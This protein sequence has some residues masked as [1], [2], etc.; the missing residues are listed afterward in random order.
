MS[1]SFPRRK[2]LADLREKPKEMR[3]TYLPLRWALDAAYVTEQG[4][5]YALSL[6]GKAALADAELDRSGK[7]AVKALARLKGGR[8]LCRQF[9][10]IAGGFEYFI[11]PGSKPFPE[12]SA[13]YLISHG[14]VTPQED[15]LFAGTSQTFV[16]AEHA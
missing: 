14:Y 1:M 2:L 11:E 8:K 16:V 3:A 9:Q 4:G 7:A 6:S 12:T 15:G 5:K 10:Q 13:E